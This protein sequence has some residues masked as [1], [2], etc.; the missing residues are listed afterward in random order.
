[1]NGTDKVKN[2]CQEYLGWMNH[3][4]FFICILIVM[5][6]RSLTVVGTLEREN[7]RLEKVVNGRQDSISLVLARQIDRLQAGISQDNSRRWNILGLEKW[8][9]QVNRK[10]TYEQRHRIATYVVNETEV[11]KNVSPEVIVSIIRQESYFDPTAISEA[12]AYGLMGVI[13]ETGIWVCKELGIVYKD[14]I[15]KDPEMSVKIGTWFYS[16]LLKKYEGK[17]QLALAHYN[18]GG[19][20][21]NKYIK[22][23][24]Y[25]HVKEYQW[26]IEE[27]TTKIDGVRDSL[28]N[29]GA[30][31]KTV[32]N[33]YQYNY[34]SNVLA[35][36][37][38]S[39]ETEKYI[40]EVIT[41]KEKIKKFLSNP[42]LFVSPNS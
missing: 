12:D 16:Y 19:R 30:D 24:K 10:L 18:G 22:R 21:K 31:E 34:F 42:D 38:L 29:M 39:P 32:K 37:T 15:L 11:H 25:K 20:Q 7:E 13:E 14:G 2:W 35:G 6:M 1:M 23:K 3:P 40:P 27:I 9:G 36:K 41:R 17:E 33:D 8:I 5:G 26:S 4:S 28:I